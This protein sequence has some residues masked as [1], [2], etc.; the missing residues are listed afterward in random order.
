MKVTA[1]NAFYVPKGTFIISPSDEGYTL[2]YSADGETFSAWDT[3]TPADEVCMV[4][5]AAPF[6][7]YQLVGN[8]SEVKVTF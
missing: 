5:N 1:E 3:P 2:N 4:V 7:V 8:A 6:T